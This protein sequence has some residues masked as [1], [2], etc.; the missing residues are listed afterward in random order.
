M[1]GEDSCPP[2]RPDSPCP[3]NL[4]SSPA[5]P[6]IRPRSGL[7]F[8]LEGP[9]WGGGAGGQTGLVGTLGTWDLE[10]VVPR[11]HPPAGRGT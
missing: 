3:V 11:Q 10:G 7:V 4:P 9:V 6:N 8:M 5:A 1:L 2:T